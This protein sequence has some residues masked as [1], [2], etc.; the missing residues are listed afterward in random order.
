MHI[1]LELAG[2]AFSNYLQHLV[3][4]SSFVSTFFITFLLEVKLVHIYTFVLPSSYLPFDTTIAVLL[5]RSLSPIT[6]GIDTLASTALSST[7]RCKEIL[8]LTITN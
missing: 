7:F 1:Y 8:L 5:I 2:L 3:V 6:L 4:L